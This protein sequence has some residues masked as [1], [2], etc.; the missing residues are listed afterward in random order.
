MSLT[1][2]VNRPIDPELLLKTQCARHAT[3]QH[4]GLKAFELKNGRQMVKLNIAKLIQSE[5]A[6]LIVFARIERHSGFV[7][8]IVHCS[9]WDSYEVLWMDKSIDSSGMPQFPWHSRPVVTRCKV[10]WLLKK[11]PNRHSHH[12]D[13]YHY[14]EWGLD[15]RSPIGH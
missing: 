12:V 14:T 1:K 8:I 7:G 11:A 6:S 10:I 5:W 9:V 2:G 4:T 15:F 3:A 13:R